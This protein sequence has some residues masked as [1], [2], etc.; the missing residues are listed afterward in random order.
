M[1]EKKL[2]SVKM[3]SITKENLP[4]TSNVDN[5]ITDALSKLQR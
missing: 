5:V 3:S 4:V 2:G 1:D